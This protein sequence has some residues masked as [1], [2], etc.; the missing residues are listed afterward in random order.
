MIEIRSPGDETFEKQPFWERVGV[1]EVVVIDRDDKSVR[2]WARSAA[3]VLVEAR[4]RL[5]TASHR[6]RTRSTSRWRPTPGSHRPSSP[7]TELRI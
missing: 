1:A 4:G 7:R 3:D 6:P 2:R 5:R